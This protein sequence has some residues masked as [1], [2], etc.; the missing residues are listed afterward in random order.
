MTSK[1]LFLI[2]IAWYIDK[3]I[4]LCL[5]FYSLKSTQILKESGSLSSLSYVSNNRK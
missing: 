2:F 1:D 5:H 4:A 3:K